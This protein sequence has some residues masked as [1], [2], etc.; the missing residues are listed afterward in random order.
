MVKILFIVPPHITS[1]HLFNPAYQARKVIKNS[2]VFGS[3]ITDMPLG[4]LSLSAYVKKH[5]Q[6]EVALID[7]NIVI[8]KLDKY[9]FGSFEELFQKI[10]S[11]KE[12]NDY[13][14]EIIA[15]SSLFTP[16]YQNMLDIAKIC[17]KLF[18]KAIIVAGGGVPTNM[19]REIFRDSTSFDALC[20]GEGEKPFLSLVMAENKKKHL[21][22]NPS[23]IT[24][25]KAESGT[26]FKHD[27]I[28]DLDEIPF[29]DYDICETDEYGINP[30]ITAYAAID[31]KKQNFHVM[32]SRGC[33][34][35][36]CFCS[37]HTVHGR[38]MRYYSIDR[39]R[40]DF[41]RLK[42]RYGAKT[43]VFQ[44]DHLMAD[45]KRVYKII[46]VIK[47]LRL[48]VVF[49]NALAMYALD[50]KMLEALKGAGIEQLS[51]SVESGSNRVLRDVMHKPLDLSIVKRV[52]DDCRDLGI[53]TNVAVLI[54]LPGETRQDIKDS[55]NF[56]KT[57]NANWFLI[58]CASP[59]VGSEMF[60][61]CK[62]N[63]Y[64]KGDYIGVDYKKAI[65]ETEDFTAEYIQE[66]EYMLNLELNFIENS[67]FRLGNYRIALKGFENVIRVRDDHAIAYYYAGKCCEKLGEMDRAQEYIITA[68]KIA[69]EVPFWRN[70][71][72][73]FNIPL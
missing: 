3:V 64:F 49:Q 68:K 30:S 7:F 26:S 1:D 52:S 41:I 31:E 45:K 73:M 57:I 6:V 39:V 2:D 67:D 14:P 28:E 60:E 63:N 19:Y 54:G 11:R 23:W 70:Y 29:Y 15:I 50:R 55:R 21:D 13:G 66:M 47:D 51:L 58:F 22:D 43:I 34:H 46:E 36:C 61:I 25:Q 9:E 48:T 24:R 53:Y 71:I 59:L 18:P 65:I 8:N 42:E 38:R 35:H 44:D 4:V 32:T 72:E 69:A 40:D 16:S 37:S 5:T 10:L 17:Q 56:L 20:Y 27:F 62:K 33:P 12:W